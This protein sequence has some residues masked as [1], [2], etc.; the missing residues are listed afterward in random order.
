MRQLVLTGAFAGLAWAAGMRGWMI[1][2]AATEG[3]AYAAAIPHGGAQSLSAPESPGS[4][5]KSP[6]ITTT[7]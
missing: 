2:L 6:S 4:F 1:Q 7:A 5:S 3:S